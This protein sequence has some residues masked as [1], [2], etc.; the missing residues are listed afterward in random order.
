[1]RRRLRDLGYAV[2]RFEPGPRNSLV[3]VAGVR[4]GHATLP[5]FHTGVTAVLPHGGNPY[6]E[7][8]LAACHIVNGYGKAAG[9]SQ[10]EELGT[11]ESPILL[12]G[13]VSVGPVWEGGLRWLLDLNPEAAIDRDTVNV[14][15]GE[16]FDGWLGDSRGLHVRPEHA[17][18]AIKGASDGEVAEG[19]VGAG[20]GTTCFGFK[21]GVGASSRLAGGATLGCLVVAN[22][23]ARREAHLLLG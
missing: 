11:L 3:D 12:T 9:L 7:K 23:G 21:S 14:V 19:A 6:A 17:L 10:L 18:E 4:V 2:G 8:V 22:Y 15:V 5:D 16:C 13:T 20:A 1:M